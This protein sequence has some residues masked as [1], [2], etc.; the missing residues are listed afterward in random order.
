MK[1]SLNVNDE[2]LVIAKAAAAQQRTALTR[3]IEQGLHLRF[4]ALTT[5]PQRTNFR[6]P[7]LNG[8]GGLVKGIN[9]LCNRALLATLDEDA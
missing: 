8:A 5:P 9:P 7:V 6:L 4:R 3:L 2:L 1:A